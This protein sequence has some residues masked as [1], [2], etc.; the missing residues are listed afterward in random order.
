VQVVS[1]Y[2]ATGATYEAMQQALPVHPTISEFFPTWLGM[3]E[4]LEND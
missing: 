1:N 4:P 3:L 2:M